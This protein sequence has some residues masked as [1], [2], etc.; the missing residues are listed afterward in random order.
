MD[1]TIAVQDWE[2][3]HDQKVPSE[4]PP[5]YSGV[6]P[7]VL[8][9]FETRSYVSV[10][11]CGAWR[12]AEEGTTEILCMA[13]KIGDGNTKLWTP[14]LPFPEE[15]IE[16][17][18]AG[19]VFEAHN[20][21]FERAVWLRKLKPLG[22]PVPKYWKDTLAV[23]A[24][25]GIPLGLDKAGKALD[26][27]IIK[28]E[29]G[30][31]LLNTLSMP[32]FGT[33]AEP[34]RE[35][36]EDWDLYQELYDYCVKDVD[37]E[38]CLADTLGDLPP[39]EQGLWVLDQRINQRGVMI[40][41]DAVNAALRLTTE[42]ETKLNTRLAEITKGEVTRATQRARMLKWFNE[43]G[44]PILTDLK[45]DTIEEF[46]RDAANGADYLAHL[47]EK[48]VEA[49]HIRSQLSKASTKKLI[50]MRECVNS[51]NRIRGLLQY[52]GAFTGRWAGRLVQPQNFP[53]PTVTNKVNANGKA[54]LDMD[55]LVWDIKNLDADA[56]DLLYPSAMEA[57]SSSLRGMFIAAPD[58]ELYVSDFSAIEA[59]VTFWVAGC[60][61]GLDVFD[62]SDRGE[63]EDIYCVTASDIVGFEVKKAL[64]STE[65]Q[66]GKIAVLGCGYQMGWPKLQSQALEAYNVELTDEEAENMVNTYREK[67]EEVKWAWYGLQEAAIATVKTGKSHY[68]RKIRYE[69]V[70][71][72]AKKPWLA[73]VLPNGRRLWYY[74]PVVVLVTPPWGGAKRDSLTYM[75]R[76]NKKGG[77]WGRIT[78]YGGMLM[79]NVVQ[80]IARDLMAEAMCRVEKAGFWIILTVHDEVIAEVKKGTLLYSLFNKLMGETPAWAAGCPIAVEG[81]VIERYQKV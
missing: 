16:L 36:R 27:P 43:N 6:L 51:D 58:H 3:A 1:R 7:V 15:L 8:V 60:Q 26:L 49:M 37:A 81:G 69:M 5:L 64:H 30:R 71:D 33:K 45:K 61:T 62:K 72:N 19:A 47:D 75:G 34:N 11:D 20:V 41:M 44:L 35:Y 22:I 54:Y 68:Y 76:D 52:C 48:V 17:I 9:D 31:Y 25:R 53:R 10:T 4:L 42:I 18:E 74:D 12:Y 14:D 66:L 38:A 2:A 67:Y 29:R 57:I 80:A 55:Q 73:C 63:S 50:K 24:N 40:D 39:D 78:T 70:Y 59:R 56:L 13:Y 32:K 23:C 77:T 65:R 79:E 21:Q 46:L 28:S